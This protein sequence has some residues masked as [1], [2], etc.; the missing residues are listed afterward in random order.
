[1]SEL[2][3][4]SSL[5]HCNILTN[6]RETAYEKAKDEATTEHEEEVRGSVGKNE[7]DY[8]HD[9]EPIRSAFRLGWDE[10]WTW[11]VQPK[12]ARGMNQDEEGS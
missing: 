9:Q 1:M 11:I 4:C 3:F 2:V 5:Y 6:A 7:V 8:R 12:P 10:I